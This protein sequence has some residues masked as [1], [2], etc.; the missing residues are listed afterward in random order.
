MMNDELTC[1]LPPGAAFE[2]HYST[3][4]ISRMWGLGVDLVR[5]IFANEEGVIRIGHEEILHK[6]GYVTLRVPESVMR[7]VHRKLTHT[8]QGKPN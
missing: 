1:G 7:R 8:K 3:Q 5:R 2:N 4:Q 6:R